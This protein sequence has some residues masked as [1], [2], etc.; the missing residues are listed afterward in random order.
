M[1]SRGSNRDGA[2]AKFEKEGTRVNHGQT[3]FSASKRETADTT[4][5]HVDVSEVP[6][7]SENFEGSESIKSKSLDPEIRSFHKRRETHTL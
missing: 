1:S 4:S 6:R 2:S 7:M 3:I 5:A